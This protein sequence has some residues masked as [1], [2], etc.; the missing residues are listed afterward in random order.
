MA[1]ERYHGAI[2]DIGA[3]APAPAE[4]E[5][6]LAACQACRA[7]LR[8]VQRAL[9]LAAAGLRDLLAA[10]PPPAFRARIRQAVGEQAERT[11]RRRRFFWTWGAAQAI[12]TALMVLA[13]FVVWRDARLA[14]LPRPASGSPVV[15]RDGQLAL[16]DTRRPAEATP[17]VPSTPQVSATYPAAASTGLPSAVGSAAR[18]ARARQST[19]LPR[20]ASVEPEVLVPPGEAEALFRFALELQ[21]RQVAPASLVTPSSAS[22]DLLGPAS[23]EGKP[24]HIVPLDPSEASGT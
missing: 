12:G 21:R 19:A 6:H 14:R 9:A 8:A 17:P 16:P 15:Q 7:E 3:G 18:S 1:C 22:V 2:A 5:T 4:F 20:T 10:E 23:L 24:L 13:V 11:C